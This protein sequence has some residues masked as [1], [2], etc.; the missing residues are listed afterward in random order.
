MKRGPQALRDAEALGHVDRLRLLGLSAT[1]IA[2]LASRAAAAGAISVSAEL[3]EVRVEAGEVITLEVTAVATANGQIEV[4]IPRVKGLQ[5]LRRSQGESTSMSW[6]NGASTMMRERRL[7]VDLETSK[8][9]KFEIPPI[10]ARLGREEALSP[11][12]SF[13]VISSGASDA[14]AKPS[15]PGRLDPPEKAERD[16]F[17][18]YRVDKSKV[19]QGDQVLVDLYILTGGGSFSL[20]RTAAPPALDGFWREIIDE[21][22]Q[23]EDRIE[24]IGNRQ[25]RAYR[26]WRA[27]YFPIEAGKRTLPKLGLDFAVNQGMFSDGRAVRRAAPALAIEVLPLPSEGRPKGF[28]PT[29]VGRYQLDAKVD[30]TQVPA[31]KAVMLSVTLS[32][33]GNLASAKLPEIQ[34]IDGFRV[35]PPSPKDAIEKQE[36]GVTGRRQADYVLVPQRGGR[37]VIPALV[38]NVFDP[39]KREYRRLE[40]A[41]IPI[42]V[43]GD[44]A[45]SAATIDQAPERPTT[46]VRADDLR[47]LRFRSELADRGVWDRERPLAITS[48]LLAP[49][50]FIFAMLVELTMARARRST[51][52]RRTKRAAKEAKGRL[53]AAQAAIDDGSMN[54][55]Y[56][57]IESALLD[58]AGEKAGRSLRGVTRAEARAELIELGLDQELANEWAA[59]L[60][61]CEL[62]RFSP[63]KERGA[64][65]MV[66]R[67]KVLLDGLERWRGARK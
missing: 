48:F 60:D 20:Q 51:P 63:G 53:M 9:G 52:E 67:A 50:L 21:P 30:S 61:A 37:L 55:A 66:E 27:A 13:E 35:F 39:E 42:H 41:A 18:R 4:D 44:P 43:E 8:V 33:D 16:I 34:S 54:E 56:A 7:R 14:N 57:A 12:L 32:G 64:Q 47:P 40:T 59:V 3:S 22:Q 28:V 58:L 49:G 62:A 25:Y 65:A 29:N 26:L 10:R 36:R 23:L 11:P 45:A 24:V 6:I 15:A 2:M 38:M 31:G 5:E 17:V 1:F 46:P 19:F